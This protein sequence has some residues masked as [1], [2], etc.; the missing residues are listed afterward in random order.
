VGK[1]NT[2]KPLT[3]LSREDFGSLRWMIRLIAALVEVP[4]ALRKRSTIS[5]VSGDN[6]TVV[7]RGAGRFSA[8]FSVARAEEAREGRFLDAA[9][10]PMIPI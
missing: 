6:V 7:L 9:T 10:V 4:L 3:F 5:S 8:S 2:K 1:S